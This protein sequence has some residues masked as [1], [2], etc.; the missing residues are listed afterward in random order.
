MIPVIQKILLLTCFTVLMLA[1]SAYFAGQTAAGILRLRG[2]RAFFR[3]QHERAWNSYDRAMALGGDRETLETDQIELLLFGLDQVW[4]GVRVRTALPSEKAVSRALQLVAR[5]VAETP[6]KAYVWSLASDT[7]FHGARLRRQNTTLDLSSLSED[8]M[9]VLLPEDR[10]GLAALETA[11]R[12]EPDNYIYHD[13]LA[14]KFMDLGDIDTAAIYCR[15]SVAAYPVLGDHRYL[16]VPDLAPELLDAAILGFQDSRR[17]ES[18]ITPG[19][20]ESEAG[21]LLWRNG[22]ARRAID[23]LRRAVALSPDLYEAQYYLG[24]ASYESGDHQAALRHLQEATRCLPESP[25]PHVHM[26][27]AQTALGSLQGAIDEFRRAREKDPQDIRFFHFLGEALEKS[28]QVKEAERQFVA[29]AKINPKSTVAWAALLGFYTRHREVRPLAD[30]CS[31]LE[32][33]A[34]DETA[35]REQCA[36]LGLESP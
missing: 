9:A 35:Y 4:A 32:L 10:L 14:E 21:V 20:I 13:L 17:Q 3:N 30:V 18:M 26:A 34:P 22:Q 23:Y 2:E 27:F 28:G 24:V 5:R 1:E 6:F 25:S 7:Y 31:N 36:A 12:L 11:S 29:A 19:T 15:R 8:P 33:L 16:T